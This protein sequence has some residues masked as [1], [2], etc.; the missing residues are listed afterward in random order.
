MKK[1]NL[2]IILSGAM[3]LLS[4]CDKNLE[5]I[6]TSP[7]QVRNIDPAYLFTNALRN[8]PA[9]D[10]M[11]ESTIVQQFVLPYNLG[12]TAGYQFNENVDGLNSGPFSVYAGSAATPGSLKN[13]AH[14]MNA[15]KEDPSRSNLYNESRIWRAYCFMWL[16]DHYGDV[17]YFE[18][19]LGYLESSYTPKYDK[20]EVIYED[21]YKELKAAIAALNPNGENVSRFDIFVAAG[22]ATANQVAFWKTLG[23]SL[24]LRLGMR[25]VKV[26]PNK[27]KSI[28]QEAYAAGVMQSNNDNVYIKNMD[29]GL[30]IVNYSNSRNNVIRTQNPFNFYLAEPF[31]TKLKALQDPRLKYVSADY[32]LL[33]STAPSVTNPDTTMANQYGFPVGYSDAT[34]KNYPG[35]RPAVGTGQDYSQIN[36]NVVGNS[37]APILLITNAQTKLLLAEAA[38]RGWL[39]GLAGTKT[40][41]QY[42]EEGVRASMDA[43]TL[44]PGTTP[45]PQ[46]LQNQYLSNPGV[47]WDNAKALEL[48]NTQYWIESFNNGYEAWCNWRRTGYPVLSPNLYNNS[49]GGGFIRRFSY[50]LREVTA[51]AANYTAAV[52][53]LGGPDF[54]TTRIFWDAP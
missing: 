28:V 46:V 13:L 16:V 38:Y 15:V 42:Y 48:I 40:A 29:N 7:Y 53:S 34:L 18:A 24:L 17:P 31:V 43:Y 36:Y 49:L 52:A 30:P 6:N 21:L 19:G 4:G 47:A 39:T 9:S 50:P 32:G 51:N 1:K 33:Q 22:A 44:F 8:T 14:V 12:T 25:Y 37:T 3:L 41:Q 10:W 23:N 26:D 2:V 54:L 27:A 35:Y 11:A 5:E 20:D 45:I